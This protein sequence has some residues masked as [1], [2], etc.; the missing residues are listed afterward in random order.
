MVEGRA[1]TPTQYRQ[2]INGQSGTRIRTQEEHPCS[3]QGSASFAHAQSNNCH[4]YRTTN[5]IVLTGL[6]IN[7]MWSPLSPPPSTPLPSRPEPARFWV[8]RR[9]CPGRRMSGKLTRQVYRS[10]RDADRFLRGSLSLMGT[11]E[12]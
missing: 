8:A 9:R 7:T 11:I 5:H 1:S 12:G 10:I 6:A 2:S 4:G 3:F